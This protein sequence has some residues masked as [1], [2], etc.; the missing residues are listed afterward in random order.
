M[1]RGEH[2]SSNTCVC[3]WGSREVRGG[4]LPSLAAAE[5]LNEQQRELQRTVS[6]FAQKE[7][8]PNMRQWDE[9]VCAYATPPK[10]RGC[11]SFTHPTVALLQ[12][13]FPVQTLR[14]AGQLGLGGGCSVRLFATNAVIPAPSPPPPPPPPFPSPIPPPPL[15]LPLP[16][17]RYLCS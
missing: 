8:L 11:M 1:P 15:P 5:G 2:C 14:K 7:L 12:E 17:L 4:P 3:A 16:L 9:E 6:E 13:V 10:R